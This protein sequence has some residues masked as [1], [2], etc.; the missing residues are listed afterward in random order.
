MYSKSI[1]Q[2]VYEEFVQELEKEVSFDKTT[3]ELLKG[4]LESRVPSRQDIETLLK[5]EREENEDSRT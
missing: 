1:T 5:R 4:L 2:R 3:I